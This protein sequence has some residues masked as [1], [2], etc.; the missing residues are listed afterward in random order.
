MIFRLPYFTPCLPYLVNMMFRHARVCACSSF[1]CRQRIIFVI[2]PA[3]PSSL[4]PQKRE[5]QTST[6]Y[7]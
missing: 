5:P 6:R 1:V 3:M 4:L 2:L 7:P